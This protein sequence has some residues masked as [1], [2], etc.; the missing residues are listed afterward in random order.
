ML[1]VLS[2]YLNGEKDAKRDENRGKPV[3]PVWCGIAKIR[4]AGAYGAICGVLHAFI[5]FH[6]YVV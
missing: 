6:P 1:Y 3:I 2:F 4:T 5:K